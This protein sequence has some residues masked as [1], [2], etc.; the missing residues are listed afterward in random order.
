[1]N[2]AL[3]LQALA[4]KSHSHSKSDPSFVLVS[5]DMQSIKKIKEKISK[6]PLVSEVIDVAGMY[7]LVVK[8]ESDS[9]KE[10]KDVIA[11]KIRNVDGVRTCLSLF[12]IDPNYSGDKRR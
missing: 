12:G 5:S 3:S 2:I 10:I 9:S 6:I 11:N 8:I 7:D 4:S 1:M